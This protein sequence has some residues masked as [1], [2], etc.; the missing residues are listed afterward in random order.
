MSGRPISNARV[1]LSLENGEIFSGLNK[2]DQEG[3]IKIELS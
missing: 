1:I 3:S 2:S